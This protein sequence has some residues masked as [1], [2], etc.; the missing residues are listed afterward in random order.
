VS[1]LPRLDVLLYAHD[2]RG[3]GHASRT[4]AIGMALR[5]LYPKARVLFLSGCKTSQELIANTP[6]DWLKLLSYETEVLHGKSC[7]VPGNSQFTDQEQA[8]LRSKQIREIVKL[9][10]PRIILADHSPVGKHKELCSSLSLCEKFSTLLVLGLR[11]IVGEVKQ[12]RS[13]ISASTFKQHYHSLLW[14]GDSTVLGSD[15]KEKIGK[16]YET[17]P[18]ECGYVSRLREVSY[19]LDKPHQKRALT[20]ISI[21][22]IGEKTT[23]F[24]ES[25]F[26][27][28]SRMVDQE[29]YFHLYLDSVHEQSGSFYTL[30]ESLPNCSVF[31]PGKEY[32][33]SLLSSQSAIIYGG[34]NSLVDVMSLSLPS[35]VIQREMQDNEQ[36]K[37]I[38]RLLKSE[39]F[40][41]IPVYEDCSHESLSCNLNTLVKRKDTGQ[42]TINF[43]GADNA[44]HRLM[45]YIL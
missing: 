41:L 7:G 5:R 37:H 6:L 16:M 13:D 40:L 4:I 42:V 26:T 35:L 20:T 17:T 9:Y 25:L 30:F 33:T 28:I 11:G 1:T 10:R 8:L 27:S 34:Y 24:L 19:Y 23:S 39:D 14:Y 2:G 32:V 31:Q 21:P 45:S 22:W 43:D 29:Q 15:E 12:I 36:Q 3:L 18:H 38:A 44:A